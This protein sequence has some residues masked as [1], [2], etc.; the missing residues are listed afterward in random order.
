MASK[1]TCDAGCHVNAAARLMPRT[2][3]ARGDGKQQWQLVKDVGLQLITF[4][5]HAMPT[6]AT[7]FSSGATAGSRVGDALDR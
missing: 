2:A 5:D 4:L 3:A 7:T 1:P 6:G